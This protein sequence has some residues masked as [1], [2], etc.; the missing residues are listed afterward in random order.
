[1]D[2]V[3]NGNVEQKFQEMLAK[4]TGE[5]QARPDSRIAFL[6]DRLHFG[7]LIERSGVFPD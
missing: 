5:S 2:T 6:C 3:P 7:Q 4:L 1:M